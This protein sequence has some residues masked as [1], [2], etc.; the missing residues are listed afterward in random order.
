MARNKI[1]VIDD[2]ES[3]CRFLKLNLEGTGSYEVRV[4]LKA[5]NAFKAAMAFVP[6]LIILDY[7][8]PEMDGGDVAMQL[9]NHPT[10]S[11]IPVIFLTAIATKS[12]SQGQ[13]NL[14]A[15]R[16]VMAK[17]VDMDELIANIEWSIKK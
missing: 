16:C 6:D 8:M 1:L 3:L 5:A 11:K 14:I 13:R 10:T 12:D 4:E 17:P 7:M 2:E 15:G 9:K